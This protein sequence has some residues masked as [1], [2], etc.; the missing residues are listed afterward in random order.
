VYE[1]SPPQSKGSA[2]TY[3]I[4]YSFQRGKDGYFPWGDL[5]LDSKG[6]SYGA[7]QFVGGK[8]TSCNPFYQYCGTV[9]EL[10]PPKQKGGKWTE[11]VLHSF[12]GIAVGKKSGDGANP[13][14]GLTFD[15]SGNLYG[16]SFVGGLVGIY[17]PNGN[18]YVGCGAIFKLKHP[19]TQGG[20]WSEEILHRLKGHPTDGSGPNGSLI[21]DTKGSL[22]GTAAG[23]GSADG[24][25]F[26]LTQSQQTGHWGKRVLCEFGGGN[27]ATTPMAGLTFT[28]SGGLVGTTSGGGAPGGGTVFRLT[29]HGSDWM[30]NVLHAFAGAP[31]GSYPASKLTFDQAGHLYGT[32]QQSGNTRGDCGNDGCGTVFEIA[33]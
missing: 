4:L 16:S 31:D 2:W 6:N 3:T 24:V 12:A 22:Y 7:T 5:T 26:K 10:S 20:P 13:N 19:N 15:G 18:G 25:A 11:K 28:N 30:L 8:G 17:C 29:P 1:L 27:G 32:T 33:P 14:G 23:G 21:F 9:F